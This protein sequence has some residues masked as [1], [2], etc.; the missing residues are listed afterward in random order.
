MTSLTVDIIVTVYNKANTI[1][2]CIDSILNQNY[3]NI[4]VIIVDDGSTDSS[5]E[6]CSSYTDK[7]MRVYHQENSGVGQARNTGISKLSGDKVVFV[8][9]D[10]KNVRAARGLNIDNLKVIKAWD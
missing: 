6:I 9:D 2:R 1:T 4:N 8:D 3:K 5:Y 10:T 7:R